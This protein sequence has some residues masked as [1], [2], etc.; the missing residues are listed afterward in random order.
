[1]GT[2]R[3]ELIDVEVLADHAEQRGP[4]DG[5]LRLSRLEVVNHYS[6]GTRSAA[7]ACDVVTRARVDA[8]TI[9][10]FQE[11]GEARY[12]VGLRENLRAPVYLRR[13]KAEP[14]F[15]IGPRH[16]TILE[17]VAGVL[18][19]EDLPRPDAESLESGLRRRAA[20]ECLEEVGL[21][22]AVEAILELGAASFPSPGVADELVYFKAA[23]VD[24]AKA[25][26]PCGDGSTMEEHGGLVVLELE[27]AI[28][29]CRD[30]R[31]PDMKTEIALVRLRDLLY[32][33]PTGRV[34]AGKVADGRGN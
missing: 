32:D 18:E 14:L 11:V 4:R 22:V 26:P 12:L 19:V 28:E 31:I 25:L 1:M 24:F 10:L 33:V 27:E 29:S 30:G 5:F 16:D 8:V 17:T 3:R 23:E 15:Q 2:K 34:S 21:D 13:K 6:D 7:Y 9:V 20:A